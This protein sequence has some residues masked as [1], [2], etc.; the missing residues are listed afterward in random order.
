[1]QG[2]DERIDS[3]VVDESLKETSSEKEGPMG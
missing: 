2:S 3:E 1:M